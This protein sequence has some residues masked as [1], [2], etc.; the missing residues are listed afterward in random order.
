MPGERTYFETDE[1]EDDLYQL[2]MYFYTVPTPGS[3]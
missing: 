1:L 2:S 3:M